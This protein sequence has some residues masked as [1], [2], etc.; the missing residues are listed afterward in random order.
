MK[1]S[2]FLALMLFFCANVASAQFY[3]VK[4]DSMRIR[5]YRLIKPPKKNV[6]QTKV[7]KEVVRDTVYVE[8]A[9]ALD[10]TIVQKPILRDVEDFFIGALKERLNVCLPL[11][12]LKI[13][14]KYGKRI[15]PISRCTAFHDGIDL[16][17]EREQVYS[18]LPA[19]VKKVHKGNRGYG[20][21]VILEHGRLECLYAHLEDVTVREG[22]AISAGTIVGIS[23]CTGKS[24][25]PHLHIRLRKDGKSVDPFVFIAFLRS[26]ITSLNARLAVVRPFSSQWHSAPLTLGNVRAEI[27]KQRLLHP[28]IVLAQAALETGNFSSRVCLEYNNLFGLRRPSNGEYYRFHR[29]EDSVRAYRD[30]VQYKYKG[31]DYYAF[32]D[33]IGYAEDRDY[34]QKIRQ[35]VNTMK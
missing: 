35:M 26:Y 20:N 7:Q 30:Y 15:D 24:T 17:C 6:V 3:S 29:W 23:G 1:L 11:D 5:P 10:T 13:T 8:K 2:F 19:I 14:S 21:Y 32:L 22:A 12:F 25:G 16:R 4:S 9:A 27:I 18:M 33:R 28:H 31:G 34:I